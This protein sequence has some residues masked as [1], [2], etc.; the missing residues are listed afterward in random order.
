M[1]IG[2]ER[3]YPYVTCGLL[4]LASYWWN[5]WSVLTA[6]Q[7]AKILANVFTVSAVALGFW[8]TAATLLFA[9]EEK[10]FVRKLKQGQHFRVLVGYIFE[11]ISWQA[12]LMGFSLAAIAF[13]ARIAQRPALGRLFASM[14]VVALAGG[15]LTTFRA[16]HCLATVLKAAASDG[17]G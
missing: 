11:A 6:H 7:S 14:W 1:R 5:G 10:S 15:A 9:V 13:A 4:G 12:I 8:G 16:Y 2:V 17:A 3:S